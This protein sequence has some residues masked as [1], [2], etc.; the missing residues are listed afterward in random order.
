MIYFKTLLVPLPAL[1]LMILTAMISVAQAEPQ[2]AL[3]LNPLFSD[4][5]VM[6]RDSPVAVWGEAT[7]GARVAVF[8]RGTKQ[9]S[10]GGRCRSMARDAQCAQ[11]VGD[12]AGFKSIERR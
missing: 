1:L 4:H 2:R 9:S 10:H 5:M 11:R 3:S 7:P 8:V 6:Q 12:R